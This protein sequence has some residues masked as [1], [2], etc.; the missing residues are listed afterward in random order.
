MLLVEVL[1]CKQRASGETW[2]FYEM[3]GCRQDFCPS[4][5][6]F[7]RVPRIFISFCVYMLL[8][9]QTVETEDSAHAPMGVMFSQNIHLSEKKNTLWMVAA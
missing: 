2:E 4:T 6:L 1:K 3:S 8:T 5:R 9:S 7:M